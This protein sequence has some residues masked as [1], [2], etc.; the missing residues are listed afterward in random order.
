L[1]TQV[2]H[3]SGKLKFVVSSQAMTWTVPPKQI[4]LGEEDLHVWRT[5]LDE[6]VETVR[7]LERLLSPDERQRAGRFLCTRDSCRFVV[8]RSFLREVL[9]TYLN[10]DAGEVQ[11]AAG[12]HGKPS[13]RIE[14]GMKSVHFNLSHSD[15]IALLAISH[16]PVGID[17]ERV[18]HNPEHQSIAHQFFSPAEVC[19]YYTYQEADRPR[20]FARFWTRK[21]AYIKATGQGLTIPLHSFTVSSTPQNLQNH[22]ID[23]VNTPQG[24]LT[25]ISCAPGAWNFIDL[26]LVHPVCSGPLWKMC[27]IDVEPG[28]EAAVVCQGEIKEVLLLRWKPY[29]APPAL[30]KERESDRKKF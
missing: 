14:P 13:L 11:F 12:P 18:R 26:T 24:R 9:G 8:A 10:I 23:R 30:D 7:R 28:F 15:S 1:T 6:P 3:G 21:E 29:A 17:I 25:P 27:G 19:E 16:Q 4:V 20:A 2:K 5:D 22:Q